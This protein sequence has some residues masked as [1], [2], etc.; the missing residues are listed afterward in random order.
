MRDDSPSLFDREDGID[1]RRRRRT[2]HRR[3]SATR[4]GSDSLVA[5]AERHR[6]LPVQ[7]LVARLTRELFGASAQADDLTLLGLEIGD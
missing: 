1:R 7:E 5:C 3:S 2:S 6:H 4:P